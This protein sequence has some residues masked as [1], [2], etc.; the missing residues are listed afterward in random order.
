MGNITNRG[1]FIESLSKEQFDSGLVRFQI[2]DDEDPSL[3]GTERVWGWATSEDK[4]KYDDDSYYGELTVI[5]LN[6]P[7]N[8]YGKLAWGDEVRVMCRGECVPILD[9]DWIKENLQ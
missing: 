5:L 6:T 3:G 4:E 2:P 8:Y 9:H 1:D 7:L